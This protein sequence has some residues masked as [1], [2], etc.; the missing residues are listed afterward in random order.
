MSNQRTGRIVMHDKDNVKTIG[1]IPTLIEMNKYGE[2]RRLRALPLR[3]KKPASKTPAI[4]KPF[5]QCSNQ[6]LS[7]RSLQ[8]PANL[9]PLEEPK[10]FGILYPL[11]ILDR[12]DPRPND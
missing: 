11:P 10:K 3:K 5:A 4:F 9:K 8:N 7:V 12:E 6:E 2:I 1:E